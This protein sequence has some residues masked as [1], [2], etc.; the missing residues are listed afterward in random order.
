[1]IYKKNLELLYQ[2]PSHISNETSEELSNEGLELFIQNVKSVLDDSV[3]DSFS[4]NVLEHIG[5]Q[6]NYQLK[7]QALQALKIISDKWL[8]ENTTDSEKTMIALKLQERAENCTPGFHNGINEIVEGFYMADNLPDL[9]FR[10]RQ[11]IV[12]RLATTLTSDTHANNRIF[13]MAEDL[14]YGVRAINRED[15]FINTNRLPDHI[16]QEKLKETF[17]K[18]LNLFGVLQ[19]V[20]DQLRGQLMSLGYEGSQSQ[21]YDQTTTEKLLNYFMRLFKNIPEV[22][23]YI[24]AETNLKNARINAQEARAEAKKEVQDLLDIHNITLENPHQESKIKALLGEQSVLN[25]SF[26]QEFLKEL[27]SDFLNSDALKEIKTKLKNT[28]QVQNENEQHSLTNQILN[29]KFFMAENDTITELNWPNIKQLLW[30]QIRDQQYFQFRTPNE[31][32]TD[33]EKLMEAITNPTDEG[34]DELKPYF[35]DLISLE[36][37]DDFYLAMQYLSPTQQRVLRVEYEETLPDM[38]HSIQ[39]FNKAMLCYEHDEQNKPYRILEERLLGMISNVED[40]VMGFKC[41]TK[42]NQENYV[43]ATKNLLRTLIHDKE[44]FFRV[45]Q[46]LKPQLYPQLTAE[47]MTDLI[48][49][50]PAL[51]RDMFSD[52]INNTPPE[53]QP[54]FLEAYKAFLGKLMKKERQFMLL[55]DKSSPETQIKYLEVLRDLMPDLIKTRGD[56]EDI[57]IVF[58]LENLPYVFECI[59]EQV[60]NIINTRD[61]F[62]H[63]LNA[64]CRTN[65]KLIFFLEAIKEQLPYIIKNAKDLGDIFSQVDM[66]NRITLI[67]LMQKQL[68]YLVKRADDFSHVIGFVSE[69]NKIDFFNAIKERIPDI[70]TTKED[71]SSIIYALS[72]KNY[73]YVDEVMKKRLP[74]IIKTTDDIRDTIL[75]FRSKKNR[76][77]FIKAISDLLPIIIQD[78]ND[79]HDVL[80]YLLPEIQTQILE[81]ASTNSGN[82]EKFYAMKNKL[83]EMKDDSS[84]FIILSDDDDCRP[85]PPL[86]IDSDGY[87]L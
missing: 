80:E 23:N 14:K 21:G 82:R 20:E 40:W 32:Q 44:A 13:T 54:Q 76:A 28:S 7:S 47:I 86:D 67:E 17:D 69:E 66:V 75:S 48:D 41:L 45:I 71:V 56:I 58:S 31:P 55:I 6:A 27:P 25:L 70:I 9:L 87:D 4:S 78:Q 84:D 52:L 33:A 85:L 38:I 1:M 16:I 59:K 63:M 65:G 37:I 30:Q 74:D 43:T 10:V 64:L 19:G 2:A 42:E 73:L 83:N 26:I 34:L 8:N 50:Y 29:K 36:A 72:H 12:S 11:D 51:M 46:Y 18:N 49:N 15:A 57:F 60:H 22:V 5:N 79:L 39:D 24:N 81:A 77:I 62:S 61:D 35:R 3:R 53:L 68:P